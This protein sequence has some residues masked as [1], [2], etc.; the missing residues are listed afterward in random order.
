ML[1]SNLNS[2]KYTNEYPGSYIRDIL[3][4]KTSVMISSPPE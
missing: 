1:T 2:N 4:T 3:L